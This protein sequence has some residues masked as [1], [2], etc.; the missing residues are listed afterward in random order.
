MPRWLMFGN[1]HP[2]DSYLNLKAI[3]G[4]RAMGR[5][6]K[7]YPYYRFLCSGQV[8]TDGHEGEEIVPSAAPVNRVRG[9]SP[10]LADNGA[11]SESDLPAATEKRA[12][13][14][15]D[16]H[17]HGYGQRE[18][19][20]AHRV[21]RDGKFGASFRQ[22]YVRPVVAPGESCKSA[23]R[24]LREFCCVPSGKC[25]EMQKGPDRSGPY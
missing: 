13:V 7:F 25:P 9:L 6:G 4:W 2:S 11:E 5:T 21:Q 8:E 14:R 1:T 15:A 18:S 16:R 19:R 12:K 17:D 22:R 3:T 24:L 23:R 20:G 10:M